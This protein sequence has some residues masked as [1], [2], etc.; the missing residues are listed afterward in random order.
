[1]NQR[2]LSKAL[3]DIL[4]RKR[5]KDR[6]IPR[7]PT[8]RLL[9]RPSYRRVSPEEVW[10]YLRLRRNGRGEWYRYGQGHYV[11]HHERGIRV[12]LTGFIKISI[13][14]NNCVDRYGDAF[15]IS[16]ALVNNTLQA[17]AAIAAVPDMVEMPTWLGEDREGPFVAFRNGLL[18]LTDLSSPHLKVSASPPEWF[19]TVVFPYDYVEAA[20]CP[21]WRRFLDQVMEGDKERIA[22]IQEWFG[23]L[24]DGRH[25]AAQVS[26]C[27]G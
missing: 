15:K 23:L 13:D 7:G 16:T 24:P 1:M 19:S 9:R 11:K 18:D 17:L 4:G 20:V 2:E 22:L 21:E 27:G 5:R 26:G 6:G 3:T 14:K 10:R 8:S 12:A 25:V